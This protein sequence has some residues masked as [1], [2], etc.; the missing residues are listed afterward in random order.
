MKSIHDEVEESVTT[1]TEQGTEPVSEA[2]ADGAANGKSAELSAAEQKVAALKAQLRAAEEAAEKEAAEARAAESKAAEAKAAEVKATAEATA[3]KAE[4]KAAEVKA[5][6]A[7]KAHAKAAEDT[8]A[9]VHGKPEVDAGAKADE[10]PADEKPVDTDAR[11]G[12]KS[13]G[14]ETD[15]EGEKSADAAEPPPPAGDGPST[16]ASPKWL[17]RSAKARVLAGAALVLVLALIGGVL[18]WFKDVRLGEGVA[19]K[20]YGQSVMATQLD[21]DVQTDKALY[22]VQPPTDG[23]KLD[24]FRRDFAKATAVSMIMEKA[25]ADRHIAV[26]DR[27]ASDML[28]RYIAQYYGDGTDGHDKYVQ[29]LANQGTSE[30]KVLAEVKRQMVL[31]Q[32]VTQVTAG[33]TASDQDVRQAFDQ[34]KAQLATP[35]RREIHNIVTRSKDDADQVVADLN[36]GANFEQEAQAKSQDDSTKDQ[37][38]N[39]GQVAANQLEKGYADAAFATPVGAVFGPVQTQYGW[40]VGRIISSQPSGPAVFEQVAEPLRQT[41]IAEK[42]AAL[43][44]DTLSKLISDADVHYADTYRPADPDGLPSATDQPDAGAPGAA[45]APGGQGDPAA[46][47]PAGQVPAPGAAPAP[48]PAPAPPAAPPATPGR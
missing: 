24:Q 48:A 47:A 6:E 41:L 28:A 13:T 10:K 14:A 19:F 36:A 15:E 16:G 22:G 40:N 23:P 29:A 42:S 44:R 12:E 5:G 26:A 17:P 20:V 21:D 27:Q 32:L 9:E 39:L 8:A 38:G 33:I 46:N 25:A 4:K 11:A 7:E 31:Q 30:A 2:T 35:E 37:G 18:Y 45:P 43:W 3:A 34:R 1:H